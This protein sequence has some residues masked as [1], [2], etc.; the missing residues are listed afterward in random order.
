MAIS[1]NFINVVGALQKASKPVIA[2]AFQR[3]IPKRRDCAQDTE[4]ASAKKRLAMTKREAFYTT[5]TVLTNVRFKY[6]Y[7]EADYGKR[8]LRKAGIFL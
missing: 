6:D 2:S 5:L 8:N 1:N 3:S 7:K 4:I